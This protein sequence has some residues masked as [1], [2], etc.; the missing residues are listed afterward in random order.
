MLRMTG[1]CPE[2]SSAWPQL[3]AVSID[4]V[5]HS[6]GRY[7]V[8]CARNSHRSY[9]SSIS[10]SLSFS[11]QSCA[12][13]FSRRARHSRHRAEERPNGVSEFCVDVRMRMRG[14]R[15]SP[16][17]LPGPTANKIVRL[18]SS[19]R[20][21]RCRCGHCHRRKATK[22]AERT[23]TDE[24]NALESMEWRVPAFAQLARAPRVRAAAASH[25]SH[26]SQPP[27]P[28]SPPPLRFGQF[29]IGASNERA[30]LF[31]MNKW[32]CVC[33]SRWPAVA[34]AVGAADETIS[35]FAC[36]LTAPRG[37][38]GENTRAQRE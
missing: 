38:R 5:L 36:R 28:S 20:P 6:P 26:A 25:A 12:R 33:V 22:R 21:P 2:S 1:L 17:H 13:H 18:P 14:V 16:G 32:I 4:T 37:R 31:V 15:P 24:P 7:V 8:P 19:K 27:P 10:L 11:R 23:T 34:T 30:A 3:G 9:A 35:Q 29:S